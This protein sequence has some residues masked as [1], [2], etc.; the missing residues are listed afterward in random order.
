MALAEQSDGQL[1]HI[2]A[3]LTD[4]FGT[5]R[6]T[7]AE[8]VM[9]AFRLAYIVVDSNSRRERD[10]FFLSILRVDRRVASI[11]AACESQVNI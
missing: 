10:A 1:A 3:L 5:W 8:S 11:S 2:Y 9:H 7:S 4:R 6:D